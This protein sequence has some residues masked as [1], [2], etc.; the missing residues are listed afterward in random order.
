MKSSNKIA[1]SFQ[2]EQKIGGGIGYT[3]EVPV[4][5]TLK[6]LMNCNPSERANPENVV[7]QGYILTRTS[8]RTLLTK[9]WRQSYFIQYGPC[10][11]L[12]FRSFLDCEHWLSNKCSSPEE[13]DALVKQSINFM[14]MHVD[15][16][17]QNHYFPKVYPENNFQ[18]FFDNYQDKQRMRSSRKHFIPGILGYDTTEITQK[19]YTEEKSLKDL[20]RV[21]IKNMWKGSDTPSKES[22]EILKSSTTSLSSSSSKS[23]C[24]NDIFFDDRLVHSKRVE[25]SAEES[26]MEICQFKLIRN[27]EDGP[28][29]VIAGAYGSHLHSELEIFYNCV[30]SCIR[31]SEEATC[32]LHN[33]RRYQRSVWHLDGEIHGQNKQ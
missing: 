5:R 28:S 10:N 16:T 4:E 1:N 12:I 25:E 18:L 26:S 23:T 8:L 2:Y 3:S 32:E 14:P 9:R 27:M 19:K 20:G 7:A 29:Q 22:E 33:S 6:F 21:L 17:F 11:I 31:F 24:S 30:S 13:R 15:D